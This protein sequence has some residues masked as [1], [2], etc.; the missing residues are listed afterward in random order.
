MKLNDQIKQLANSYDLPEDVIRTIQS[1]NALLEAS[2]SVPGLDIGDRAPEFIL[3]NAYGKD[4]SLD[5]SLQKG[6]V[7][8]SFYRGDWCPYCN[9]ELRALQDVLPEIE[10]LGASLITI[11]PQP[12][13]NAL[14]LTEKHNLAFE[15]LSDL[16]QEATHDYGL[17]YTVPPEVQDIYLNV[18][19]LDLS[20]HTADGSWDLPVPA[21]FILDR[22]GIVRAS[23]V[24]TNFLTR[25]EPEMVL[26]ELRSIR[27]IDQVRRETLKLSA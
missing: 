21:T 9:L 25:M 2:G 7:V 15:V 14:S 6:L 23:Y 12:P 20:E 5:E 16:Y 4:I 19:N 27:E 11:S 1:T 8:L 22:E 24:S 13:T 3:P 17:H 26:E 10:S 18:F